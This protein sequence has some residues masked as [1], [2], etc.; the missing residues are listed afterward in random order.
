MSAKRVTCEAQR[1]LA[2][3]ADP[4]DWLAS[5]L[6]ISRSFASQIRSGKRRRPSL[7][8]AIRIGRVCE[9]VDIELWLPDDEATPNVADSKPQ[10]LDVATPMLKIASGGHR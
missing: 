1:R 3:R 5:A 4:I 6:G 2:R 8:L 9:D 10:S 7:E